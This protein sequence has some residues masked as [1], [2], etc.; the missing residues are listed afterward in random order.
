MHFRC[1]PVPVAGPSS[2]YLGR[3]Q[4]LFKQNLSIPCL[5]KKLASLYSII[6]RTFFAFRVYMCLHLSFQK[7]HRAN[8]PAISERMREV[9]QARRNIVRPF[10]AAT[11]SVPCRLS[12]IEQEMIANRKEEAEAGTEEVSLLVLLMP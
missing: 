4:F 8:L 10:V 7:Q 1:G 11:T 5:I 12:P 3:S 9:S 6:L 2:V